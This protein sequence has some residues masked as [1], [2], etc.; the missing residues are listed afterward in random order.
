MKI[1]LVTCVKEKDTKPTT[2]EKMYKSTYY[3][4]LMALAKSLK[5]DKIFI[6]SAKYGLLPL[7][8]VIEPYNETLIGKP[9]W[10]IEQWA[11][12]VFTQMKA[13]ELPEDAEYV[14]L[15]GAKYRKYLQPMLQNTS[16][17]LEGLGI[18]SQMGVIKKLLMNN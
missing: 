18:G 8:K 3:T 12:K 9:A 11:E 2:A 6:L 1:V 7:E 5:P 4:Y 14:F 13:E 17:P 10:E 16:V 15:A